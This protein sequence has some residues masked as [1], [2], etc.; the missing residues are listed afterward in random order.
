ME[1]TTEFD[2]K[3]FKS[4]FLGDL[5]G[6]MATLA[7]GGRVA[8]RNRQGFTSFLVAA[9]KGHTDICGLLLAYGSDVNEMK[10]NTKN[11]ALHLAAMYGHVAVVEALLS[12]GAAVDPQNHRGSTPLHLAC[13]EGHLPCVLALLKAGASVTLPKLNGTIAIHIAAMSNKVDVVG[14]LLGHGCHP[15]MVRYDDRIMSKQ[16]KTSFLS[17][18]TR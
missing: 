16:D 3:L 6:V 1:R 11:T 12:W 8:W 13:Q 9:Q 2:V 7:Q 18:S 17:S 5:E 4:S 15:D 10:P 14:T